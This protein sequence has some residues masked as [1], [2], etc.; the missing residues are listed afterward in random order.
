MGEPQALFPAF[1]AAMRIYHELER[2]GEAHELAGELLEQMRGAGDW[3]IL[4]F[5]FVAEPLGYAEQLR[6]YVEQL[7]PTTMRA[8]NLALISGD[9]VGAADLMEQIGILSAEADAR[10]LAVTRLE[11]EGRRQE[12]EDQLERALAFYRSVGAT[13]YIR[14]CEALRRDLEIPA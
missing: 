2:T 11:G 10:K 1:G 13:R 5:S 6:S 14:E 12:A 4:D 8:M 7:P 3:R 9:Y